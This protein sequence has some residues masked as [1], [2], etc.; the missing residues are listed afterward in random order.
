MSVIAERPVTS[1]TGVA[2]DASAQQSKDEREAQV[3]H[4]GKKRRDGREE[5][6]EREQA[7]NQSSW[8]REAKPTRAGRADFWGLGINYRSHGVI[9]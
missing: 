5:R 8:D 6:E 3:K 1:E 7:G 9:V 2:F 4:V